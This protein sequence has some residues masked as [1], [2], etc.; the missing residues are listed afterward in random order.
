M[1]AHRLQNGF[2]NFSIQTNQRYGFRARGRVAAAEGKRREVYAVFA[3][4]GADVADYAGAVFVA[5]E[6]HRAIQ[7]GFERD[8]VNLDDAG[9][10]IVQNRAF[11]GKAGASRFVWERGN[12]QR[13]R[14]A[15]FAAARF[16]LHGE[17]AGRSN[18]RSVYHI[19][20]F[21]EDCIEH[22]SQHRAA[23]QMRADFGNFSRIAD[24][25]ARGTR[26]GGL[27]DERAETFGKR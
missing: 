16:L 6:E 22:A 8:S 18:R 9:R 14:E 19:H 4:S 26:G 27:R 24:A 13:V 15:M 7:L 10:A 11:G 3:E 5:E 17:P 23:Q 12:L 21:V 20:F 2:G 1:L 25:D